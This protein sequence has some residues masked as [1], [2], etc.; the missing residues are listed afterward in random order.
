MHKVQISAWS[1]MLPRQ[2]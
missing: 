2:S 1:A